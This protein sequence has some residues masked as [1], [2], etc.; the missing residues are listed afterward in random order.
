MGQVQELP[1]V[2]TEGTHPQKGEMDYVVGREK[3]Q[4]RMRHS[5]T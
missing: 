3:P 5:W 4:L 1:M 2:S